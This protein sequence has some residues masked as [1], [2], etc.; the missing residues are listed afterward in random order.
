M[1]LDWIRPVLWLWFVYE[2][3]SCVKAV[4]IK[5]AEIRHE[6]DI[7]VDKPEAV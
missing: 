3:G 5:L 4:L 6:R 7:S 2:L 1:P